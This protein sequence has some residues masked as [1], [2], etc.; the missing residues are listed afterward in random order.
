M[1]FGWFKVMVFF[2]ESMFIHSIRLASPRRIAVSLSNNRKVESFFGA[3]KLEHQ[4][5]VLLE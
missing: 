1:F 2:S 3:E 5:L 4:F